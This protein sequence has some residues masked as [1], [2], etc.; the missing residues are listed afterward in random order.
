MKKIGLNLKNLSG[1]T[2]VEILVSIIILGLILVAI[3]PLIT[4]S[5]Q[6]VNL[7]NVVTK[8]L[9]DTQD[10]F[11][12]VSVTKDGAL[13]DDGT[14]IPTSSFAVFGNNTTWVTGMTIEKKDLVRFLASRLG[15][16]S[17]KYDLNEGYTAEEAT[18]TIE[19][20]SIRKGDS[21]SVTI[22]GKDNNS[23][24]VAS[25]YH[26]DGYLIF[27]LNTTG[28]NRLTNYAS[29][30]LITVTNTTLN[31]VRANASMTVHLPRAIIAA[32]ANQLLISSSNI[33]SNW[34]NADTND[35]NWVQINRT[36][37]KIN[38]VV[39]IHNKESLH[40]D[41]LVAVA[42][43]GLIYLW[44][45][46][47]NGFEAVDLPQT[48]K[49]KIGTINLNDM[50]TTSSNVVIVGDNGLVVKGNYQF[51]DDDI[52]WNWS[53]IRDWGSDWEHS[54]LNA[55]TYNDDNQEYYLAGN[56]KLIL[57]YKNSF[58]S[59]TNNKPIL[60]TL[61]NQTAAHF[62]PGG[63][64]LKTSSSPV[65]GNN[66]RTIFMVVRPLQGVSN[67]TLLTMASSDPANGFLVLRT[68]SNGYLAAQY[69]S[70][71]NASDIMVK[72]NN[73]Q[74]TAG[75]NHIISCR[76]DASSNNMILSLNGTTFTGTLSGNL[77]TTG[78]M[79]LG[80]A[81]LTSISD[82]KDFNGYIGDVFAFNSALRKDS[83]TMKPAG[84]TYDCAPE[85]DIVTHY[86]SVKYGIS[87]SINKAH[88]YYRSSTVIVKLEN[89]NWKG[90]SHYWI[91]SNNNENT[92][93][94]P[95]DTGDTSPY[96]FSSAVIWLD[97]YKTNSFTTNSSSKMIE[98]WTPRTGGASYPFN[99][100]PLKALNGVAASESIVIVGGDHQNL[101]KYNT[102]NST[103]AQSN[104]FNADKYNIGKML[105]VDDRILALLNDYN[106]N[107]G[108]NYI[109]RI[110]ANNDT[111]L[112]SSV[113]SNK[114]HDFYSCEDSL[115][116]VTGNNGT[117][118]YSDD[119]GATWSSSKSGTNW[120]LLTG[121]V[122]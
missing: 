85:M 84:I 3:F 11:E 91:H 48:V 94:W 112:L 72:S 60:G 21:Y 83:F 106:N 95:Y 98:I 4:Q 68:D 67:I 66:S 52:T 41:C 26:D 29:P 36:I 87:T 114:L 39:N 79:Q 24:T 8:Q 117:I 96:N 35:S 54:N 53:V 76:Y 14:F 115:I 20:N 71:G 64:Y 103:I 33:P 75:N 44:K 30:Y 89:L 110:D 45:N 92:N 101:L 56:N 51:T 119:K 9:F 5:L 104:S 88:R 38:K 31:E 107:T 65:S 97:T 59:L 22:T 16:Q 7:S 10:S 70:S 80:S 28:P 108:A 55:I 121:C 18:Y 15:S 102:E 12:V 43:G 32:G 116:L 46:G 23:Y 58:D 25:N 61:G 90:G 105:L 62:E 37:N 47:S 17:Y 19:D 86:L 42:D 13:L 50:I 69:K 122:R 63:E 40:R 77:N 82:I 2:L 57:K 49:S 74:L 34:I 78:P 99:A 81:S 113:Y 27:T 1:M 93:W 111:A 120:N 73:L 118:L 109:A 100:P 6:A